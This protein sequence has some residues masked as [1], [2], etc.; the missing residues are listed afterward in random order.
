MPPSDEASPSLLRDGNTD[1]NRLMQPMW[2]ACGG[3]QQ[4]GAG[5]DAKSY[6]EFFI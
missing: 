2:Q 4:A 3:D 6:K 1:R 5:K